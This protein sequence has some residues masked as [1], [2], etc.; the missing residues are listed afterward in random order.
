M[1][2]KVQ[3]G[4]IEDNIEKLLEARFIPES[5]ENY[6]EDALHICVEKEIAMTR[7]EAVLN[8]LRNRGE[9]YSGEANA[10]IWDNCKYPLATIQAGQNQKQINTGGLAELFVKNWCKSHGK[11]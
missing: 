7:N 8:D 6:P 5:D 4:N 1:L 9:L 10:K 2:N 11:S 3:V